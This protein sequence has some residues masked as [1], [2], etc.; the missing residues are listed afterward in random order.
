VSEDIATEIRA[1]RG[2]DVRCGYSTHPALTG[3]AIEFGLAADPEYYQEIDAAAARRHLEL[4]LHHDLAYRVQHMP[5]ARAA[6]LTARFLAPFGTERVRYFTNATD[7][8]ATGQ[9]WAWNP[10]TTATFDTGVLVVGPQLSG[11]LWV[12]DED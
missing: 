5:I 4:I 11:C 10:V 1:A 6:E 2:L 7:F 3:L 9:N 12:E 8:D